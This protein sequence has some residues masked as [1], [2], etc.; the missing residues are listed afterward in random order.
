MIRLI[1][2]L[3]ERIA[4]FPQFLAYYAGLGVD[5]FL[6]TINDMHNDN[7]VDRARADLAEYEHVVTSIWKGP[8]DV[9]QLEEH[10]CKAQVEHCRSGDWV[11][12]TALDEFHEYP[13]PLPEVF[14]RCETLG[15]NAV[16]GVV[17]DR[18][19]AD[20][21]LPRLDPSMCVFSAFPYTALLTHAVVH[22]NT[23][24][25]TATRDVVV[26]N[27]HQMGAWAARVAGP[28]VRAC[29]DPQLLTQAHHFKWSRACV[30]RCW[31][32]YRHYQKLHQ[33]TGHFGFFAEG[34]RLVEHLE[35]H[36]GKIN[37]KGPGFQ[38]RWD[39]RCLFVQ[40]PE[41]VTC[42]LRS[43]GAQP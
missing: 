7:I 30:D 5:Q 33:E 41:G 27:R 1:V 42:D 10:M 20:G 35:K 26:R 4:L 22:A 31:R 43:R 25:L 39:G 12:L 36:G 8:F 32:R 23:M 15:V 38:H 9:L 37:V 40:H 17:R 34:R 19:T 14:D 11:L 21:S 3:S 6:V 18:T 13:M 2:G 28:P 29:Q 16:R 24:F